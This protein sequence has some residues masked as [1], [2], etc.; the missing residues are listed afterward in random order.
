[1]LDLIDASLVSGQGLRYLYNKLGP[2]ST[3]FK[4]TLHLN[5]LPSLLP[6]GCKDVCT[7]LWN[8]VSQSREVS[9][10]HP[11]CCPMK[12]WWCSLGVG[13]AELGFAARQQWQHWGEGLVLGSSPRQLL[14]M[15]KG[16]CKQSRGSAFCGRQGC[17]CATSWLPCHAFLH[18]EELLHPSLVM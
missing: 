10:L 5:Q 12:P 6:Y 16:L 15:G 14:P 3:S 7:A 18:P 17:R 2:Y 8:R 11:H 13:L 4:S 1:M 9:S